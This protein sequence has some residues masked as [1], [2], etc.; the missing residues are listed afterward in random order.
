MSARRLRTLGLPVDAV[1]KVET[2]RDILDGAL[3]RDDDAFLTTFVN[4]AS[5]VLV[6]RQPEYASLLERFHLVLPDGTGMVL[7]SR[8]LHREN[9]IRVSFDSTSLAPV[10][11]R[12]AADHRATVALV[13]GQPGV[14]ERAASQI[15]AVHT[16]LAIVAAIDG[17]RHR[18]KIVC[19]LR[20]SAP[21]IVICGMGAP[22]QELLLTELSESWRG[23]GF[24]CGGYLDQLSGGMQY[25]PGWVDSLQLRFAYRLFREPR[26]L[27]RRYLLEY[28]E[29][30]IRLLRELVNHRE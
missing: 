15:T 26:R 22:A 23:L 17:Y 20:R 30:G 28:P 11:F 27:W 2:V 24:T 6:N 10:L 12:L 18:D 3:A 9:L 4:P 7:A 5:A 19:E 29:F 25:Y 16:R 8:W 1:G 14:A 21:K 13:G